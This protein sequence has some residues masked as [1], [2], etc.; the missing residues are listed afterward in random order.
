MFYNFEIPNKQPWIPLSIATAATAV[1]I[2]MYNN[3]KA[4]FINGIKKIREKKY[5]KSFK[6]TY[7]TF[8][9]H[10]TPARHN[11]QNVILYRFNSVY[12]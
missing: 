1:K 10:T 12:M 7:H 5:I 9:Q 8:K 11:H 2:E 4:V 6:T 3:K